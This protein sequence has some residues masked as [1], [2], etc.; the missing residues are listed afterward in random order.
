MIAISARIAVDTN[1]FA[2]IVQHGPV[3]SSR[4]AELSEAEEL[5]ISISFLSPSPDLS[6]R[7]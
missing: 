1:L 6:N 3:T 2:L 4:L 5:L 7:S